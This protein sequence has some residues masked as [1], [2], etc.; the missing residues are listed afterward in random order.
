MQHEPEREPR[1]HLVLVDDDDLF[2]ESLETNLIEAGYR[3]TPFAEGQSA[4]NH[5]A[6]HVARGDLV[7][8]DWKMPGLTG[9]E[10][11][12][13]LRGEG[14]D[15]PVI[16]LTVLSDQIYEETALIGG[17]I[18]FVE[19]SRSFAILLKRIEIALAYSNGA[20][21]ALEPTGPSADAAVAEIGRLS[22][23][24]GNGRAYWDGH[25]VDLTLGEYGIVEHLARRAGNDVRYRYIYDLVRGA[26]FAAGFGPD[27]YRA[28][29]RTAIKR[30]RR[31]FRDIDD[32]FDQI[33]NYP[34]FGYRW[35]AQ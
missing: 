29:V 27:G 8:L 18:D 13:R 35:R 33:E 32:G 14:V 5:F 20:D 10:V 28:N 1:G 22:L 17:A 2:R 6:S 24:S 11:L 4:V 19:K 21:R 16:C 9:I 7:L 12:K 31:K 26:G 34:G 15:V 23:Q 3:V 30:I 25:L